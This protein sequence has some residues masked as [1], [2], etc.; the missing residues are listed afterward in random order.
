MVQ[1]IYWTQKTVSVHSGISKPK[2]EK[3]FHPYISNSE[4]HD[5]LLTKIAIEEILF[6]EDLNSADVIIIN[7]DNCSIQYKSG[8]HFYHLQIIANVYDKTII[9]MYEI[10]R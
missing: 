5:Q 9:R 6:E 3:I 10:P 8:L 2:D 1:S 7:S 4:K